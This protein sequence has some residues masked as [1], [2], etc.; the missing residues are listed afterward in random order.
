MEEKH[1]IH[2]NVWYFVLSWCVPGIHVRDRCPST[3]VLRQVVH[4]L[5]SFNDRVWMMDFVTVKLFA[6][7]DCW[8]EQ[9]TFGLA[10]FTSVGKLHEGHAGVV[11]LPCRRY[12][13]QWRSCSTRRGYHH[14]RDG[15]T[16]GL[17]RCRHPAKYH[18]GHKC[19]KWQT[20]WCGSNEW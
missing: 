13:T 12:H 9:N 2:T 1:L 18:P 4:S 11:H 5:A 14:R 19:P 7:I 20:P 15:S 10:S 3:V 8:K 6:L 17:W 16:G